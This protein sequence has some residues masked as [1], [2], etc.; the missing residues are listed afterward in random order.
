M[1]PF[2]PLN[3]ILED[4]GNEHMDANLYAKAKQDYETKLITENKLLEQFKA[5]DGLTE[6]EAIKLFCEFLTRE[7]VYL[8]QHEN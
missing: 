4:F 3:K 8:A 7:A 6:A 2:P 5:R 1:L